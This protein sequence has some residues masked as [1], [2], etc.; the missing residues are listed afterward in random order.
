[1]FGP[2]LIAGLVISLI[3]GES[4]INWYFGLL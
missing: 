3:F 4:F 2:F 1:P